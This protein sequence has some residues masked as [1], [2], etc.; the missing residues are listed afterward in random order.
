LFVLQTTNGKVPLDGHLINQLVS[1][2]IVRYY[3]EISYRMRT[4]ITL[5]KQLKALIR[6]LLQFINIL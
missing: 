6:T 2:E 4:S 3:T 5:I 1:G